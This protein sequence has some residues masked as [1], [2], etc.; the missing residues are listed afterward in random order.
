MM[1]GFKNHSAQFSD[2]A[3]AGVQVQKGHVIRMF[4]VMDAGV[5][6]ANI[7]PLDATIVVT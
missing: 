5:T 7:V 6:A 4:R 2:V 1:R 3:G